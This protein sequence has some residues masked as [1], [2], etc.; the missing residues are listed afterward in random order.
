MVRIKYKDGKW[1]EGKAAPEHLP[2]KLRE[3]P[4]EYV[5]K[6][7]DNIET[8]HPND[9]EDMPHIVDAIAS[10]RMEKDLGLLDEPRESDQE[11]IN[12]L[13][14]PGVG[15]SGPVTQWFVDITRARVGLSLFRAMLERALAGREPNL[16]VQHLWF[17]DYSNVNHYQL[18]KGRPPANALRP[19]HLK[20]ID[21]VVDPLSPV[22]WSVRQALRD[23]G[24][25]MPDT[26]FR[27]KWERQRVERSAIWTP[28]SSLPT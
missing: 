10:E 2:K 22:P 14:A 9:L 6:E 1:A 16:E 4:S 11:I 27:E 28:S 8:I 7:D 18:R 19:G 15:E 13:R 17:P 21:L 5:S 25:E 23:R 20:G 26:D 3:L 24:V 12:K